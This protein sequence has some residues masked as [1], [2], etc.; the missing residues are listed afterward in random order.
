MGFVTRFVT[1][2]QATMPKLT[3]K[4][5][6][7]LTVEKLQPVVTVVRLDLL[8]VEFDCPMKDMGL[9]ET[10]AKVMVSSVSV[11]AGDVGGDHIREATVVHAAMTANPASQTFRVRLQVDNS[12]RQWKA[13]IKVWVQSPSTN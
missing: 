12:G 13:G 6:S 7:A 3:D 10:G 8:W 2:E 5:L 4:A 11:V 1:H 9:F